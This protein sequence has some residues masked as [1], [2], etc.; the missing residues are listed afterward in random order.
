MGRGKKKRKAKLREKRS[1][2]RKKGLNTPL[3]LFN[4]ILRPL[5]S[6]FYYDGTIH[7]K[8]SSESSFYNIRFKKVNITYCKFKKVKFKGIDFIFSNLKHSSFVNCSFEDTVFFATNI[9]YVKFKNCTFKNVYFFNID[10]A[11]FSS[12]DYLNSE[13]SVINEY[14][15][16]TLSPLLISSLKKFITE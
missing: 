9:K 14:P 2:K 8:S 6:N 5:R 12:I 7:N 15:N 11:K 13:I 4:N 3:N 16:L 10:I 1:L